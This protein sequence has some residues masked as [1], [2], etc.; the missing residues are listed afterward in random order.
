MRINFQTLVLKKIA[1]HRIV[2]RQPFALLE[3]S[4]QVNLS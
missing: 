2:A 4:V 1:R 3:I